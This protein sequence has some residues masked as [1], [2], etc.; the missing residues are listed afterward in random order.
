MC[1]Q[2]QDMYATQNFVAQ[3]L[4]VF[5]SRFQAESRNKI[6]KRGKTAPKMYSD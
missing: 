4:I 6:K 1:I 2:K 5:V 3:V